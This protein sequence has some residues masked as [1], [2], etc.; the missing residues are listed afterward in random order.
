M[1]TMPLFFIMFALVVA[2]LGF[3]KTSNGS[4]IL[5]MLFG[6]T[7]ATTAFGAP[8]LS[9]LGSF[10]DGLVSAASSVAGA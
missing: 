2:G 1:V 4:L 9:A 3:K 7:L 5:G 8:L 6:L 10:L